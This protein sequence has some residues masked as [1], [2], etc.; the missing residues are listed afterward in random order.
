MKPVLV[1]SHLTKSFTNEGIT[2]TVLSDVSFTVNE[3]EF[4]AI[5]GASGSGKS[6]LLSILAGLEKPTSGFVELAGKNLSEQ[7]EASLALI[8]NQSFGFVFQ[9]F[10]LVPS[11]TAKENVI[12][13]AELAGKDDAEKR[14]DALL[15]RVGV[16]HRKDRFPRQL[17]GGE[18]QRVAIAR[19]LV[20]SPQLIFADEPTGNLDSDNGKAILE[21]L[22]SVR[23]EQRA[24]LIIVTHEARLAK[25]ADRVLTLVD[26]KL[27]RGK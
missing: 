26:G 12:F 19:A 2:T 16:A 23:Q 5:V 13:P 8:R 6:T 18:Q 11:F 7:T 25:A 14:A 21:L 3:G 15:E 20:N 17:S 27:V 4:I 10:H 24:T 1:A 22:T 9:S